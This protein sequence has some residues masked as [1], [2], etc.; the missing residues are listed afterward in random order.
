[1][2]MDVNI[3]HMTELAAE[4]KELLSK[5]ES[6]FEKVIVGQ[7]SVYKYLMTGLLTGGH[8]LIEGMPGLAKTLAVNT[9]AVILDLD[10]NRIQFTP[11]ML[12]A[13]IRGTLIYNQGSGQFDVK[14]GPVFTNF[15]LADEINRAPAKVQSALLEAMQE[16]TVTIG[17]HTYALPNPFFV[18]A[19]QNPIEQEGTYPLPEAQMDRFLLKVKADYP[20]RSEEKR[21]I[22]RMG[23]SM[24]PKARTIVS[25]DS[26]LELQDFVK[27]IYADE[28]IMDY[29]VNLVYATREPESVQIK[30]EYIRAGASP[31]ASL[32]FLKAAKA[33]AFFD[34]RAYVIPEDIKSIAHEVLRH[35]ILISFEAEA[36]GLTSD[37][38]IDLI[39]QRVEI[40]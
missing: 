4:K 25:K 20:S 18:M 8:I 5:I 37:S 33:E 30:Q 17:D 3:R 7:K 28:K 39:L 11:D 35:R 38:I 24:I 36:E 6:E 26:V 19:T 12:P 15:V 10:F 32:A 31:R 16:K 40:P 21:I 22:S 29:I 13:D 27:E 2:S 9:L 14:K 1:M 34:G 23:G